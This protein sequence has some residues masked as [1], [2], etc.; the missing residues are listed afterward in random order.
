[1]M[2]IGW[3]FIAIITAIIANN[4][5]RNIIV[6]LILGFLFGI[7]SLITVAVLPKVEQ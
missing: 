2:L 7:F 4:K 5:N 6:W 3:T 1:M